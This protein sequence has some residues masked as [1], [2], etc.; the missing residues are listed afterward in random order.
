MF[1]LSFSPKLQKK[2][3]DKIIQEQ[4]PRELSKTEKI[5][6]SNESWP[7]ELI[8]TFDIVEAG[9]YDDENEYPTWAIGNLEIEEDD[10][11]S[12]IIEGD[13]VLKAKIDIDSGD[14]YKV[15]VNPSTEELDPEFEVIEIQEINKKT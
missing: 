4:G 3:L 2:Y 1:S 12:I 7:Y 14:K 10:L 15:L 11:V 9:G 5:L 6:C 13:V 8:G